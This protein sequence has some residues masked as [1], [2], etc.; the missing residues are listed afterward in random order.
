MNSAPGAA[1]HRSDGVS[2]ARDRRPVEPH[3][4]RSRQAAAP[5]ALFTNVVLVERDFYTVDVGASFDCVTYW[6]GLNR[7]IGV[8]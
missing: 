2:R 7:R 5:G 6:N 8:S 4:H 1:D 3:A